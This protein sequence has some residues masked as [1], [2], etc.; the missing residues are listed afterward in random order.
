MT[1][2]GAIQLYMH[3]IELMRK[4]DWS[5]LQ[6]AT[7]FGVTEAAVRRWAFSPTATG[8]RNPPPMAF[9]LASMIDRQMSTQLVT[10]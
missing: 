8:Y 5:Y 7:H 3:P 4:Y 2:E 9:I 10:V 1:E 6:L